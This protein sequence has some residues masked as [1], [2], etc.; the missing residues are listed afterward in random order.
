[1]AAQ[2]ISAEMRRRLKEIEYINER[3]TG[4]MPAF[5]WRFVR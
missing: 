4:S 1:M 2:K 3:G 5:S